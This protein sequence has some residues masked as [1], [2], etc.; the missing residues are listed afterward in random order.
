MDQC[1][2]HPVIKK[3][4][5]PLPK[6]N[7]PEDGTGT[8]TGT[9]GST[10]DKDKAELVG[11]YQPAQKAENTKNQTTAAKTGDSSSAMLFAIVMLCAAGALE[12]LKKRNRKIN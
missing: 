1:Q 4:A 10:N 6:P 12:L 3:T 11:T 5:D 9:G 8:E 7:D 2:C